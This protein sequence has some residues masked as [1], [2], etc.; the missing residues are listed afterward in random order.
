MLFQRNGRQWLVHTPAKLNLYL[1]IIG[2]R[3]DGF[4][5]LETFMVAVDLYDTLRF[6]PS[7][8]TEPTRLSL[9]VQSATAADIPSDESNLVWKAA[10]LLRQRTGCEHGAHIELY[11][12]IPAQAGLGGGSSDAAATLLGLNKMWGLGVPQTELHGM[13]AE[14]G[15][16]INFF[17]EQSPAA[18]CRGRG[19]QVEAHRPKRQLHFVISHPGPGL[20]TPEVF[21]ACNVPEK[22]RDIE[23]FLSGL[24]SGRV[25]LHNRLSDAAMKIRPELTQLAASFNGTNQMTGSGS[26][27][28]GLAPTRRI[29]MR[30]AHAIRNAHPGGTTFAVSMTG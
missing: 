16:D 7:L 23:D 1:E 10:D 17:I 14:L 20:S 11:K 27:W 29:A 12:R 25:A 9:R 21:A 8:P 22:P 26:A 13:A 19:E 5:E 28:F 3:Y 30:N 4:H 24:N 2:R 6:R 18:V 15:S